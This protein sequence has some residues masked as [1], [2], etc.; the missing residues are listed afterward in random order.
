MSWNLPYQAL[1]RQLP[2]VMDHYS[3]FGASVSPPSDV[4]IASPAGDS[5]PS[6]RLVRAVT[7]KIAKQNADLFITGN[8]DGLLRSLDTMQKKLVNFQTRKQ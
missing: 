8:F 2:L 3:P 6:P 1:F 4:S 5:A 7:L